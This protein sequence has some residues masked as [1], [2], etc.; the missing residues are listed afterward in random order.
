MFLK[1]TEKLSI[2]RQVP[3]LAMKAELRLMKSPLQQT[4]QLGAEE[5]T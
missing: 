1:P 2:F 5:P 4:D 3:Q